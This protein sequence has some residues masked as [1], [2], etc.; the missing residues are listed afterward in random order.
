MQKFDRSV[1]LLC[2]AYNE[3]PNIAEYLAKAS[4]LM[5]STVEDYEIVLIDDGST[6][7]TY[8]IAKTVQDNDGRLKIFRNGKNLG[9]GISHRVAISKASKDFLFWQTVDWAYDIS[10]L[11]KSLEHLKTFDV[12]QGVRLGAVSGR[13]PSGALQRLFHLFRWKHLKRRSDSLSKAFVSVVN[14]LLVRVLFRVPVSDFQNVTF[15][16]TGWIQSVQFE[17]RSAFANPEG[18]IKAYWS[19]MRIKEVPIGFIPRRHGVAKGTR[20]PAIRAAI[21]DIIRLW[22]K[23]TV[24]GNRGRITKGQVISLDSAG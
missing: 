10:E 20:F 7:R 17:A 2:W 18:L 6:D 23:W 8:N 9:S 16:S 4:S 24:L 22:F 15:Y 11:R 21:F 12:V 13:R 19:G 1:S 14:Y 5:D 3:E